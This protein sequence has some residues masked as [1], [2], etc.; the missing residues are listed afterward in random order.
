VALAPAA[1]TANFLGRAGW[2]A[3]Y[4]VRDA[5]PDAL[6]HWH[7]QPGWREVEQIQHPCADGD[8]V[9]RQQKAG[10]GDVVVWRPAQGSQQPME[11]RSAP[12]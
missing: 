7:V 11:S 12:R 8:Y 4:A 10:E 9:W 1:P 2:E 6:G 3:C 5:A